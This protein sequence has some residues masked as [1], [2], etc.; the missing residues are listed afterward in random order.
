MIVVVVV[1]V[2]AAV[3]AAVVVA[4]IIVIVIVVDRPG[5]PCLRGSR[6]TPEILSVLGC[7]AAHALWC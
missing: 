7:T 2:A 4:V 5:L 6:N 1:V 3:V